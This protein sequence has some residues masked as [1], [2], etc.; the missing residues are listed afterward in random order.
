LYYALQLVRCG[1][2]LRAAARILSWLAREGKW[3]R[4]PCYQTVRL[5]LL[6]V[7][8]HALSGP[9]PRCDDWVWFVD[10]TQQLGDKKLLLVVGL[11]LSDWKAERPL[12][13]SDMVLLALHPETSSSG[14]SLCR[15]LEEVFRIV[16]MPKAIVSDGARDLRRGVALFSQ[17]HPEARVIWLYDIKHYC[18]LL[19]KGELEKDPLWAA[20]T[21]AANRTKQQCSVTALAAL[22]PP[23]QRGKARYLNLQEL[24]A[25]ARKMLTL[26]DRPGGAPEI[27]LETASC[28]QK[29][30]WLREYREAI[31]SW[32]A[33][34]QVVEITESQVRRGGVYQG[35]VEELTPRLAVAATSPL[36]RRLG[37]QLLSHLTEQ[38]QQTPD[39]QRLPASSEVL[40][41]LIGTYKRLHGEHGHHGVTSLA[42]GLG[43]LMTPNLAPM[44]PVA[45]STVGVR[46]LTDWCQKQLGRTLQSCRRRL[47]QLLSPGIKPVP[48]PSSD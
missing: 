5:W 31:A 16:G 12:D 21:A 7:G 14:E 44:L 8:L 11:R 33:A 38:A 39:G 9:K 30:G 19:L 27:G 40:E 6:R 48:Q 17:R 29:L 4:A 25:W 10:H 45:L 22:N 47:H 13:H 37:D 3:E 43:T 32:H 20:F 2:S 46:D 1:V 34:M 23:N 42:L 26:L 36:S 35:L 15:R 24:V 28:E 18:A 41:S